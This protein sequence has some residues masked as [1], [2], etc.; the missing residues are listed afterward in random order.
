WPPR[1]R[2]DDGGPAGPRPC[3][4]RGGAVA[5]CS[6]GVPRTTAARRRLPFR[7]RVFRGLRPWVDVRRRQPLGPRPRRL[8]RLLLRSTQMTVKELQHTPLVGG[9]GQGQGPV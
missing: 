7:V 9:A 3:P 1:R 6:W 2:G 8:P 4:G 5:G